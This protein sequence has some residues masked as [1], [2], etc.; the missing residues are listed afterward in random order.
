MNASFKLCIEWRQEQRQL[1]QKFH[2]F[3]MNQNATKQKL[4]TTVFTTAKV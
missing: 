1:I 2:A 4:Q 3:S